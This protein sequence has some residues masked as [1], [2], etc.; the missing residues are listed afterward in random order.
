MDFCILGQPKSGKT[1]IIR[2]I[3]T[4]MNPQ[5]TQLLEPTSS[6]EVHQQNIGTYIKLNFFDFPG[7]FDVKKAEQN[8]LEK[9]ERAK[10]VIYLIDV[11]QEP[12]KE[13]IQYFINI[14]QFVKET[15]PK[16]QIHILIHKTDDEYYG[17]DERKLE[18][19]RKIKEL[20]NE[21]I[22]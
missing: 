19:L 14:Y 3:L 15:N 6:I 7:N 16:A 9:L 20:I 10:S 2:V 8:Q 11:Q 13:S 17:V 12:Y 21:E 5:Q 1:S 18:T 4:K 22:D